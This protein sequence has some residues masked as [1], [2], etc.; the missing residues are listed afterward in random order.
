MGAVAFRFGDFTADDERRLLLRNGR[1]VHLS[2]KSFELLMALL[3]GRPRAFS[4]TELHAMLWPDTF[5]TDANLSMLIAEIRSALGDTARSPRFIR[6]VQRHG[7]AFHCIATEVT[8]SAAGPSSGSSC[9]ILPAG[10]QIPLSPGENIVGRDPHA[11][12]WLDVPGVSRRH[13]RIVVDGDTVTIED[14]NSKN[15]TSVGGRRI[16]R[17]TPLSDGAEIRFG[18]TPVTFRRWR[19]DQTTKSEELSESPGSRRSR[20]FRN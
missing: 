13:A 5:V 16:G 1:E 14:L 2:P 6:T 17:P 19:A 4:K 9:W 11:Q 15:G 12:V 3:R 20:T 18:S 10:R 8:G 7:Y